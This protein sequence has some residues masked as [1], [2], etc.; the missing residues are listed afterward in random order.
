MVVVVV[1]VASMLVSHSSIAEQSLSIITGQRHGR[2]DAGEK[3]W[4]KKKGS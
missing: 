1:I 3:W 2:V 4:E